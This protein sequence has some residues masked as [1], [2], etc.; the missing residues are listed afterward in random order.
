MNEIYSV[1]S[2]QRIVESRGI[3]LSQL[4]LAL[5]LGREVDSRVS[6]HPVEIEVEIKIGISTLLI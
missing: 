2:L 3:G 6:I 4:F 1:M 5:G